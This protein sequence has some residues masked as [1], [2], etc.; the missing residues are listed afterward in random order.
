VKRG[1]DA[2]RTADDTEPIEST[3]MTTTRS[4]VL[5][6]GGGGGGART[7][8]AGTAKTDSIELVVHTDADRT[9]CVD[10]SNE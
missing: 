5:G 2:D 8:D 10:G 4:I 3:A 7:K 1:R 6:G 9:N